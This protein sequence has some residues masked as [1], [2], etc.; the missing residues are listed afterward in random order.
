MM[1]RVAAGLLFAALLAGGVRP[2]LLRLLLPPHRSP[3][4]PGPIGGVD[5]APL[6]LKNDPTPV[7]LV[8]FVEEVRSRTRK[9]ER[10]GLQFGEPHHGFSYTYWRA[11]YLLAGRTVLLPMDIVAPENADVIAVWRTGYGDPRYDVIF[12]DTNSAIARR[13]R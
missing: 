11:R 1:R 9:G 3:D 5:R 2:P 7:E 6:R 8:R 12:A 10:I 4:V 13:A